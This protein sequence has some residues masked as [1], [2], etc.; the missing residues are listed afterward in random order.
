MNYCACEFA[1]IHLMRAFVRV[2]Q[3]AAPAAGRSKNDLLTITTHVEH[4][5]QL[6]LAQFN[7]GGRSSVRSGAGGSNAPGACAG[8]TGGAG[9]AWAAA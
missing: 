5:A 8:L 6:S 9:A 1:T 7:L 4:G 3:N 2:L